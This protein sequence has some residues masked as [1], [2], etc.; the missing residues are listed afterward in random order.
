MSFARLHA[1]IRSLRAE[2]VYL[3]LKSRYCSSSDLRSR[4]EVMYD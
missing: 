4:Q 3:N 2:V 1:G